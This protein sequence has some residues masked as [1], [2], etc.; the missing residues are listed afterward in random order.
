[1]EAALPPRHECRGFRAE[2]LMNQNTP[3]P[4]NLNTELEA[5][6]YR[7]IKA[8]QDSTPEALF[9][10]IEKQVYNAIQAAGGTGG[11]GGG[12]AATIRVGTTTTLPPGSSA[13][14]TN[15]GTSSAAVFNFGIPAGERG[16][17]GAAGPAGAQGAEGPAG[18]DGINGVDGKDG[19]AATITVGAVTTGAPETAAAVDNVGT[20][21]AA[22]FNFTIPRGKD[23]AD[24]KDGKDGADGTDAV[25]AL[26]PRGDYSVDATP[27][28]VVNDYVSH[29][30]NSYTCKVDNPTNAAPTTGQND[31]PF[32]QLIALKGAKGD[33]GDTGPQGIQGEQGEAGPQGAPGQP[34]V[35]FTPSVSGAGELSWT[36]DGGLPN[37]ASVN[38]MGPQGPQGAQ[39][40]EGPQGQ[41]GPQGPVGP[42]GP[43]GPAGPAGADGAPGADGAAATVE[44]GTV[45]TLPA[46]SQA[47]VVNAGTANAAR[48]NFGIPQGVQGEPGKDGKDGAQ[49]VPGTA[50]TVTVGTVT[51]GLPGSEAQVVNVGTANA[52]KLNFTIPRGDTG[53]Q[54]AFATVDAELSATSTN[55]VQNKAVKAAIDAVGAKADKAV[56]LRGDTSKTITGG[57][58][59][60][61]IPF[62]LTPVYNTGDTFTLSSSVDGPVVLLANGW[63]EVKVQL[64]TNNSSVAQT[65]KLSVQQKR[66]SAIVKAYDN[67]APISQSVAANAPA[68][69][70][71]TWTLYANAN[72]RL[73]ARAF[74]TSALRVTSAL[75]TVQYLGG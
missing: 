35:T 55:P 37:P 41:P 40:P 1:M 74:A 30:G 20:S 29:D 73:D 56:Q 8:A 71:G 75:I 44:V 63:Y 2:D 24:G 31:D 11:G 51:T 28:Y 21:T 26:V 72:D 32:W 33:T 48:F 53:P 64:R 42:Q 59:W 15:S 45:N 65:V 69:L 61:A 49:G 70:A 39:G 22:I 13:T 68:E 46:G 52:A 18:T 54:G 9:T 3:L 36:N 27:A 57:N 38:V 62:V 50:A 60:A 17:A 16:E 23:G 5:N 6:V 10:E 47:T 12:T 14:V 25:A 4:E 34:G 67:N 19:T 43:E 58:V 7:A 66:G